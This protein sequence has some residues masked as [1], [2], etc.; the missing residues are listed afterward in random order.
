MSSPKRVRTIVSAAAVSLV[1]CLPLSAQQHAGLTGTD[2]DFAALFARI[3]QDD[4]PDAGMPEMITEKSKSDSDVMAVGYEPPEPS[5]YEPP[6]LS[7]YPAPQTCCPQSSCCERSECCAQSLCCSP[8]VWAEVDYMSVWLEGFYVPPLVTSAPA[9]APFAGA[10][11]NP[12]T[13]LLLGNGQLADERRSGLRLR[14]GYWLNNCYALQFEY[15][16][17]QNSNESY[18]FASAPGAFVF[19]PFFNTNPA[20]NA[21]DGELADTIGVSASS[22]FHSASAHLRKCLQCCCDPCSDTCSRL[23]GF[24]GYRHIS[25]DEN[26][27]IGET[28]SVPPNTAIAIRDEFD[29]ENQFHGIEFG[30]HAKRRKGPWGLDCIA[31]LAVGNNRETVRVAGAGVVNTPPAAPLQQP[32][33]LLGQPTNIGKFKNDAFTIIPGVE[34]AV[35]RCLCPNLRAR[36]GYTVMYVS[37]VVRPGRQID[38]AVDGRWLDPNFVP[39]GAPPATRPARR[40]V[41]SSLWVQALNIGLEYSF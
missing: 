9:V 15:F 36:V 26:L 41:E 4:Q 10:I 16:G 6:E 19:R 35:S 23:D 8:R 17:T 24:V 5:G 18:N 20:V 32:G 7:G 39:P 29:T 28:A 30:L 40:F 33:G 22:S 25:L 13:T 3:V 12:N 31:R 14:G 2:P 27:T 11:N 1:W 34:L 38:F 37:D 21:Q